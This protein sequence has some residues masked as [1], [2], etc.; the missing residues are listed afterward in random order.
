VLKQCVRDSVIISF[1]CGKLFS[2]IVWTL[3]FSF[4]EKCISETSEIKIPLKI[5]TYTVHSAF[6]WDIYLKFNILIGLIL[7]I[8]DTYNYVIVIPW[9]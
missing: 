1:D 5:A 3:E 4:E 8:L 7:C 6:L 9:A 2:K